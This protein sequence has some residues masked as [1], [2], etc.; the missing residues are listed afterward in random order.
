MND[1]KRSSRYNLRSVKRINYSSDNDD[2][3]NNSIDIS[4]KRNRSD[5]DDNDY[6]NTNDNIIK[7]RHM[8][9]DDNDNY[10]DN[11]I[12][13]SRLYSD[14]NAATWYEFNKHVYAPTIDET[15]IVIDKEWVS[16]TKIKN[17]LLKDPIID[18]LDTIIC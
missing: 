10:E 7:K 4:K 13:N 14:V 16:A 5:N 1:N 2:D 3:D 11:V 18:W 15:T 12:E 6:N 17:Y 8:D 9:N